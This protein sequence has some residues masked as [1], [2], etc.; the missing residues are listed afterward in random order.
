ML[1]KTVENLINKIAEG[2][3]ELQINT[4][5]GYVHINPLTSDFTYFGLWGANVLKTCINKGAN[6][7]YT[8]LLIIAIHMD[9]YS[10]KVGGIN[11]IAIN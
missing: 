2:P 1:N 3:K 10:D 5:N 7:L 4:H 9:Y 11:I 6:T 8:K